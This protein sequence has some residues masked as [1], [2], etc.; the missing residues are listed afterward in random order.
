MVTPEQVKENTL[1]RFWN[2]VKF[3]EPSECWEWQRGCF[4]TGY[5]AFWIDRK[6]TGSHRY[7]YKQLHG[8]I[9]TEMYVCHSCD[10]RKCVNPNH[11]WL[12]TIRDNNLDMRKK[13]RQTR[14]VPRGSES[15]KAKLTESD[16]PIIRQRLKNESVMNIAK[17]Y[18]LGYNT[19]R[20][21]KFGLTWTHVPIQN[22]YHEAY[23]Q[24]I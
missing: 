21:I 6:L 9:P 5:G 15:S 16:I 18:G 22:N 23:L 17:S 8:N 19:I 10:N 4:S 12:G 1:E 20:Y 2:S 3:G 24:T 11:F 13:G 14:K 7:L